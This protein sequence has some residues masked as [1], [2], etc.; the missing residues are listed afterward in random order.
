MK[1]K[2]SFEEQSKCVVA[3]VSVENDF[4]VLDDKYV[5]QINDQTLAEAKRLYLLAQSFSAEQT[6]RKLR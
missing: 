4:N 1:V 2:I 6:M 3:N 5:P